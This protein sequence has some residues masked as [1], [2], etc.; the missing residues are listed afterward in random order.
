[1]LLKLHP[2][3]LHSSSFS[4]CSAS[5]FIMFWVS[6]SDAIDQT[7]TESSL[8]AKCDLYSVTPGLSNPP[9]C[10]V[11]ALR[12]W[13]IKVLFGGVLMCSSLQLYKEIELC[14]K[15]RKVIQ[16]DRDESC[17]IGY[18]ESQKCV[19]IFMKSCLLYNLPIYTADF[20]I[21]TGNDGCSQ[22]FYVY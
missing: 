11:Y 15:I 18:G 1:M 3:A 12:M 14:C 16:F 6:R 7:G 21:V 2:P 5:S 20:K 4:F 17:M 8:P 19:I 9:L 10:D 13:I 22:T